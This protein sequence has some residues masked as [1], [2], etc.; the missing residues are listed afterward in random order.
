MGEKHHACPDGLRRERGCSV[1]FH[2]LIQMCR[3][4]RSKAR[5]N[6]PLQ[7]T[8]VWQSRTAR[9]N[10]KALLRIFG[11]SSAR[12][13]TEF[14]RRPAHSIVCCNLVFRVKLGTTEKLNAVSKSQ[15]RLR[16]LR[17]TIVRC[18]SVFSWEFNYLAANPGFDHRW[19]RCDRD[20]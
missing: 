10:G 3:A 13:S 1:H 12:P 19:H 9:E 18:T 2:S 5:A 6:P 16:A 15:L 17:S 8:A 4:F 7:P 14:F 20:E 11:A